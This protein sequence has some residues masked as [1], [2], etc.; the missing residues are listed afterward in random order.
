MV[1]KPKHSSQPVLAVQVGYQLDPGIRRKDRP[2]EDTLHVTQGT[3]SAASPSTSSIPY[4]L[5]LVADGMGG[6]GHGQLASRLAVQSLVE[7]VSDSSKVQQRSPESLL[8]AGVQYAKS[9]R[10]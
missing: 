5:L 7:Y 4:V 9:S 6:Q 1:T 10:L 2:N 8:S 3:M